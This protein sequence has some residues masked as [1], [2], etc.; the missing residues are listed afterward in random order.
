VHGWQAIRSRINATIPDKNGLREKAG[1]FVCEPVR[2]FFDTVLV[3]P[4]DL[5]SNRECTPGLQLAAGFPT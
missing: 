1:L 2:S 3:L 5:K 4:R